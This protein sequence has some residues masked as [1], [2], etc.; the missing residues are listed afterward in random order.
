MKFTCARNDRHRSYGNESFAMLTLSDLPQMNWPA[1]VIDTVGLIDVLWLKTGT[2]EIM[3]AFEVEKSTSIYSGILR[4]EDLARSIPGG[5]CSLYLV[6]PNE[7]ERDV[8]TQVARPSF[9]ASL[10]DVSLGLLLF[11]DLCDHG[12]ALCK[13]GD[14]HK[15]VQKLSRQLT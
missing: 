4:L 10:K 13:F 7:R 12:Q 11:K 15:I 8:E 1:E 6:V 2:N 9:R 5:L 3:S 14:D